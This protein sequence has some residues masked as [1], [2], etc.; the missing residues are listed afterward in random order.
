VSSGTHYTIPPDNPFVGTGGL[1]E[2]YASGFRHPWRISFDRGMSNRLVA[3]DVG[4]DLWE[5]I[6]F[7]QKGSNYGWRIMEGNH[8]YDFSVARTQGL[9]VA[10]LAYPI[11]EYGHGPL[12]IAAIGG[13]VYRGTNYPALAGA[14]IFGDFSTDFGVPDGHLYYLAETRSNIWERFAFVLA[15]GNAPLGRYVKS[16]GEDQAGELYLLSTGNLGPSGTSGDI[17]KLRK[18]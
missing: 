6:D 4:Q 8:A 9:D 11:H 12:G 16:F 18:P 17:R 15:P 2:V 7:V 10:K 3:A 14:Y 1:A 5:E 13:G